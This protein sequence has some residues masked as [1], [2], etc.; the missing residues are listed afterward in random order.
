M[1]HGTFKQESAPLILPKL[2]TSSLKLFLLN[3]WLWSLG[4]NSGNLNLVSS[5]FKMKRTGATDTW[6]PQLLHTLNSILF[7]FFRYVSGLWQVLQVTYSAK[8]ISQ[9]YHK[10]LLIYFFR[11]T[12]NCLGEYLPFR[13]NLLFSPKSPVVPNSAKTNCSTCSGF[14]FLS[15]RARA[16]LLPGYSPAIWG[17]VC[18][19]HSPSSHLAH[20]GRF[21]LNLG[22]SLSW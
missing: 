16:R 13:V 3:F 17:K 11:R 14:L 15:T 2:W 8:T 12:S 18:P 5:T 21:N 19:H 1:L 22:W 9:A 6:L 7:S 20:L 10:I 4:S